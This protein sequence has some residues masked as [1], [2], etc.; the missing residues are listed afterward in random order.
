M[1]THSGIAGSARQLSGLLAR[2]GQGPRPQRTGTSIGLNA[3]EFPIL[4]SAPTRTATPSSYPAL[5]R[6][7]ERTLL[8]KIMVF[9]V[10]AALSGAAVN[11]ATARGG[12]EG[13]GGGGGHMGG[14]FGGEIASGSGG[15]FGSSHVGGFGGD[16]GAHL[17]GL[18]AGGIRSAPVAINP[19]HFGNPTALAGTHAPAMGT[20]LNMRY[21]G[22]HRMGYYGGDCLLVGNEPYDCD[23]YGNCSCTTLP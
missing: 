17:G 23:P 15:G 9:A 10:A 1:S 8:R 22:H 4:C 19:G 12:G 13:G 14:G 16:F 20:R 11:D 18:C 7:P 21:R 6:R 2:M 5:R 3:S